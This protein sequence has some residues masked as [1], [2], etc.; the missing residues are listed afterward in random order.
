MGSLT[1]GWELLGGGIRPKLQMGYLNARGGSLVT[2]HL[3]VKEKYDRL[4]KTQPEGHQLI[5]DFPPH[6]PPCCSFTIIS[7]GVFLVPLF[8]GNKGF[9][10]YFSPLVYSWLC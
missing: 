6:P 3:P 4:M 10:T 1:L 2:H 5:S 9:L 8:W 7:V